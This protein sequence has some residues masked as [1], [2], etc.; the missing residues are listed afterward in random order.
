MKTS[1]L[2]LLGLWQEG[3]DEN[4]IYIFDFFVIIRCGERKSVEA[5]FTPR[6]LRGSDSGLAIVFLEIHFPF[7]RILPFSTT[8]TGGSY[9]ECR[10]TDDG[11]AAAAAGTA[12]CP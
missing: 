8:S 12:N 9:P 11:T 6:C 7:G 4:L 10:S 5:F 1:W 2:W 3:F